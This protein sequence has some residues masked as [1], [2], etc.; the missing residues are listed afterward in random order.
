[1]VALTDPVIRLWASR[2]YQCVQDVYMGA[3]LCKFPEDLRVYEHLLWA[4]SPRVVIEIGAFGGGSALWFR[5]R[6][7]TLAAYGRVTDP[8][9][10]SVELEP[11]RTV[12]ALDAADAE[13]RSSI[14]L[15]AGDV[16]D[17]ATAQRVAE[18]VPPDAPALVTEDSAH[19][20][21]T[22]WAALTYFSRFVHP[23]GYFVVED[24]CVDIEELRLEDTWPRG[25]LPAL[26]DWLSSDAGQAFQVRRD[27]ELYGLT[28]NPE[29][30]LQRVT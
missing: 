22:T 3:P 26:R 28:C 21:D 12:E 11:S 24:G 30:Y 19:R 20:Y 29:G 4:S 14:Q 18:I 1:V 6:L 5:D 13:W 15:V 16:C 23:G 9:V 17:P 27:Y 8:L 25:V 7:R 10:V 2:I